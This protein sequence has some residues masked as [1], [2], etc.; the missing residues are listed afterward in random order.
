VF[1]WKKGTRESECV[2]FVSVIGK[3]STGII[4]I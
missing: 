2:C 1:H 3:H 4:I